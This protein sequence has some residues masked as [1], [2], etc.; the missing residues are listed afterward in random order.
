MNSII[1]MLEYE[2]IPV[3]VIN[4]RGGLV[5]AGLPEDLMN[6]RELE[7]LLEEIAEEY[8]ALYINNPIEFSYRGFQTKEDEMMFDKKVRKAIEMLKKEAAGK[9]EFIEDYYK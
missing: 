4:E 2:C 3:W 7:R 6:N 5:C 1:F 9:Y 8:D